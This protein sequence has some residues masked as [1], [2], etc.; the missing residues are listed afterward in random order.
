MYRPSSSTL[1][2]HTFNPA[3]GIEGARRISRH[4]KCPVPHG[5]LLL[6]L[7]AGVFQRDAHD[8][9]TTGYTIAGLVPAA[10]RV[11]HG[12]ERVPQL[13]DMWPLVA[14]PVFS[15]PLKGPSLASKADPSPASNLQFNQRAMRSFE[16][17]YPLCEQSEWRPWRYRR[18]APSCGGP[19]SRAAT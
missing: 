3:R 18:T 12:C 4:F 1:R 2:R 15:L 8:R 14:P 17:R 13:G 7:G 11:V 19:R 5:P 16:H 6:I 9:H 10:R